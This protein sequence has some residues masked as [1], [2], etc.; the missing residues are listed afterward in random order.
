MKKLVFFEEDYS[1][2]T[3]MNELYGD[4]TS[5]SLDNVLFNGGKIGGIVRPFIIVDQ[6]RDVNT[7]AEDEVVDYIKNIKLKELEDERNTLINRG[8]ESKSTG[9]YFGFSVEEQSEFMQTLTLISAGLYFNDTVQWTTKDVG[10]ITLSIDEFKTVVMES[11]KYKQAWIDK[12]RDL[13]TNIKQMTNDA[14]KMSVLKA[15]SLEKYG[16][17]N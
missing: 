9:H 4:V 6:D 3:G 7:I 13:S 12:C 5:I 8:F 1:R 11:Q 16:S 17:D 15:I 2:M 14:C 10:L